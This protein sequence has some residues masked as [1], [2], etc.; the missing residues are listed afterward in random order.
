MIIIDKHRET[1]LESPHIAFYKQ[2][3]RIKKLFKKLRNDSRSKGEY[4]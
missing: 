2:I 1:E 3:I 4:R